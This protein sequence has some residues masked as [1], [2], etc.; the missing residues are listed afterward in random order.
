MTQR[1]ET[2]DDWAEYRR[3]V[4]SELERLNIAVERLKDRCIE[5]QSHIQE[6]ISNT[7]DLL[8]DK[9]RYHPN[10]E[11]FNS[12]IRDINSL[13]AEF[14]AYKREQEHDSTISSKW[15]FWSAVISI[16]GSLI[17]SIISLAV[18]LR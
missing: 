5:I 12:I 9:L 14:A 11:Q 2:T 8:N 15:G 16:I 17:V 13:D 1:D 7:K 3:L 6:E 10:N 18:S 4:L